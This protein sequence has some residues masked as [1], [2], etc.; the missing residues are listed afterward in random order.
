MQWR[1]KEQERVVTGTTS[2][3]MAQLCFPLQWNSREQN[4][5]QAKMQE[6][7]RFDYRRRIPVIAIEEKCFVET[8]IHLL[9]KSNT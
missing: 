2:T 7:S 6:E 9:S 3:E 5:G 1:L 8:E 4:R